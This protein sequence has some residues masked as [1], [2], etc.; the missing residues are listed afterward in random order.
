MF[1]TSFEAL[2]FKTKQEQGIQVRPD[3]PWW[4]NLADFADLIRAGED[5]KG[6][7]SDR[8]SEE[9]GGEPLAG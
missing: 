6:T 1:L 2:C 4:A 7:A 5:N 3:S 9:V 8:V